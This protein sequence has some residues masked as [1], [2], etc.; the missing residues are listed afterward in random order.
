MDGKRILLLIGLAFFIFYVSSGIGEA[1]IYV[2]ADAQGSIHVTHVPLKVKGYELLSTYRSRSNPKPDLNLSGYLNRFSSEIHS[3]SVKYSV[4]EDLIRA[5]IKA[6]SDFD[7]YAISSAGALGLMQ[8]MPETA[9]NMGVED[10]FSPAQ[11]IDGGVHYLMELQ[12]MFK[13]PKLAIAAYHAGETRV[14]AY[15]DVPPIPTTLEYVDRVLHYY[16]E[17]KK[18]SR[19]TNKIY[20]VILP[21]G[22][23]LY[24]TTPGA[25]GEKQILFNVD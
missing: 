6:E 15:G 5:V 12:E 4:E 7:P 23:V 17:F 16:R 13:D 19:R 11:N 3:A 10:C 8:L 18:I 14:A 25:T 21:S 22:K 20:K 2:Y 9:R 24:S 1:D